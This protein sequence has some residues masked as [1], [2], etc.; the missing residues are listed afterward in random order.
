MNLPG[1]T[2]EASAYRSRVSYRFLSAASPGSSGR[3]TSS[4]GTIVA[5]YFPGPQ[6]QA[7][8]NQCLEACTALAAGC[9]AAA[10]I[11]LSGCS[12]P[13]FCPYAVY[14]SGMMLAMCNAVGDACKAGCITLVCCPKPCGVPNPL[15]PGEG[16]CDNG[17]HCVDQN[18]P[19]SRNGC[20]PSDQPVCGGTCCTK[21]EYCCGP[22]CCPLGQPCTEGVCGVYPPIIP[23]GTPPPGPPPPSPPG[24]C[25][26]GTWYNPLFGCAPII[27]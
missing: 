2:A 11:P 15:N 19:N 25:P 9:S 1:F 17:E 24:G 21:Q 7:G 8:C 16:C 4:S 13:L 23:P 27:H 6:T 5:A 3:G 12:V 10:L 26:P 18:D 22:A 14:V 20:C